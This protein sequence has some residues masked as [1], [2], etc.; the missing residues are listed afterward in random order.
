VRV[1]SLWPGDV[2][3]ML[4]RRACF[5][6]QTDHPL[7]P[8][9]RLVVWRMD[10]G[11]WSHDALSVWQDVGRAVVLD[12]QR[13]EILRSAMLDDPRTWKWATP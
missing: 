2:I 3:E 10:D 6:A 11:S 1:G 7:W 5:I 13:P 8:H 4:G 12:V 9:L